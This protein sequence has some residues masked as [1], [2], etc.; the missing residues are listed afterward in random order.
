MDEEAVTDKVDGT[1]MDTGT[2]L[3]MVKLI[4]KVP[5]MIP[6]FDQKMIVSYNGS[7]KICKICYG[8]H[9]FVKMF[10]SK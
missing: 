4:K 10:I 8:Y 5:N 9:T 6:I 3:V 1:N 2:Y 7:S